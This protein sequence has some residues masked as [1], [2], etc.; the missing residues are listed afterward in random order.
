MKFITVDSCDSTNTA[1]RSVLEGATGRTVALHAVS[2]TAGRGQRGNV[3]ESDPGQN[4]TLSIAL[5]PPALSPSRHFLISESTAVA[6][7]DFLK[8]HID[9]SLHTIRIK[10][11]NDIL[12][13]DKKIAGILIENSLDPKGIINFSIIGIGLN[14]NQTLFSSFIPRATSLKLL[15]GIENNPERLAREL[16]LKVEAAIREVTSG[17]GIEEEY[18]RLL[19][20]KDGFYD[21]KDSSTNEVF[22]AGIV[23]VKPNGSLVLKEKNGVERN[24]FFKEVSP[25]NL[26]YT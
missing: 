6:V 9:T 2:Q 8:S 14:I 23:E 13:D 10:W 15:S 1:I 5:A 21:W 22:S 4:I 19:W 17:N 7:V 24:Y 18:H 25:I 11:P 3:W 20:R 12:V 26:Q 16:A